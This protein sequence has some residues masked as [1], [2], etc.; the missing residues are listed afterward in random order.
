MFAQFAAAGAVPVA[1]YLRAREF[2]QTFGVNAGVVAALI[3]V[4]VL[5]AATTLVSLRLGMRR[6]QELE[7]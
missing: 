5:C 6:M 7:F 4:A 1:G 2:G 3:G